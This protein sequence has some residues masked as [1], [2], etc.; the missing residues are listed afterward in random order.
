MNEKEFAAKLKPWLERSAAQVGELEATRLKAARLRALDAY[1]EPVSILGLATVN[2]GTLENAR[3]TLLQR[4]VMVLPLVALVAAL[5]FQSV[6][7]DADLGEIDAQLLTR[8]C[9][10]RLHRPGIPHVA[11]KVLALIAALAFAGAAFAGAGEKDLKTPQTPWQKIAPE[12]QKILAPLAGEWDRL[13]GYQQQRLQS[14]AKQYPKM[15]PI[16]R[17][18][19]QERL[20]GWANMSPEQ[21]KAARE[22]FQGLRKLPPEKQHELRERWLQ[23]REA[24]SAPP[25]QK[26][27]P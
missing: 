27:A 20:Q 4:G 8:S 10:G 1:R 9:P 6:N 14:A 11:R 19:F 3:Y 18:R 17:E 21:R 16:Q 22:S 26:P 5:A 23:K 24:G 25:S 12:D 15:Q 7:T 2:G 13:P